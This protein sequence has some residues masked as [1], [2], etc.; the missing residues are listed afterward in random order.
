MKAQNFSWS[1]GIYL[2]TEGMELDLHNSYGF[3]GFSY[4]IEART[5][6]LRWRRGSGEWVGTQ[7]PAG[8]FLG[9]QNVH[10]FRF[11]PRD[12]KYAFTE[13]DCL[14]SFGYDSDEDWTDGQFWID[15]SA[16]PNW[17]WS[18][19]CQSGAEVIVGGER[20]VVDLQLSGASE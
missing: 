7:L 15:G 10:Y 16:D 11:E 20:A 2:C 4:D 14:A 13:D 8:I 6:S 9:I 18:F 12:Q 3:I 1:A 5:V 17:R 19:A